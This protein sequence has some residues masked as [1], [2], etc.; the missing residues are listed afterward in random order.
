MDDVEAASAATPVQVKF[1]GI[2]LD[3]KT[4]KDQTKRILDDVSGHFG[5]AESVAVMGPS[6]SGK[7]TLLLCV[8]GAASPT[9]GSVD[10]NGAPFDAGTMRRVAS[11]VPQDD[12]LTPC[13]T[14]EESLREAVLF[15]TGHAADSLECD[16]KV[17]E[18][19]ERFGL[20][21]CLT[22]PVGR[23]GEGKR[24]ASGGQRRRLSV[25]LELCGDPSLLFLDE[26]TSG[27][28]AVATMS[29][30]RSLQAL[31]RRGVCCVA[32]I[33]QPS[34]A[35]FFA[36][37]RLLLL[38]AGARNGVSSRCLQ[39]CTPSS[40]L[41]GYISH[42]VRWSTKARSPRAPSPRRCSRTSVGPS[43]SSQIP[44]T[45]CLTL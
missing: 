19:A 8:S 43:T 35:A 15:K 22:T 23:P 31:A 10:V 24:G 20:V 26:P 39:L 29:L 16:Q 18:L 4:G 12:L 6:G 27:L 13:L 40:R 17:N 45:R 25:A 2:T 42:R 41:T 28:D 34:A 36:F 33:H 9:S 1:T 37:D 3:V 38:R 21:D 11:F 44:R 14:V 7:T 30:V 5:P 32:V